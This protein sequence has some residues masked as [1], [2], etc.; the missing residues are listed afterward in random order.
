L[1]FLKKILH[2]E[3]TEDEL[4]SLYKS[5]SEIS[6]VGELYQ[7]YMH[8]VFGVCMKYLKDEED[9]KDMSMQ[10]FEKLI[11]ELKV[12]EVKNFKSWLHVL[13][14]NQC[15]MHLRSRAYKIQNNFMV[16]NI[17]DDD[18]EMNYS[19]HHIEDEG[20]EGKLLKLEK[21]LEELP[22]EQRLCLELFYLEKKCYKEI[23]GQT[24]YELAKVKSYI[25][26]GKRN[27]KIYLEK[28][29]G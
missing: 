11:V 5:T 18:M 14:K 13:T 26:N 20:K 27:L 2:K 29:I 8:L 4:I 24:G 9:S 23:A 17:S 7:R 6:W 19:L 15:L 16:K 25:Q 12:H 10:I 21:G 22:Q 3:K 28:K 1:K